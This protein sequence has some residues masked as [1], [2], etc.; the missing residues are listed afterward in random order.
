M[1]AVVGGLHPF[2]VELFVAGV[3]FENVKFLGMGLGV[4]LFD[5]SDFSLEPALV[6]E[7]NLTIWRKISYLHMQINGFGATDLL[8]ACH[9]VCMT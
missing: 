6:L 1:S 3:V 8:F 7:A 4:E 2:D 5:D 9:I